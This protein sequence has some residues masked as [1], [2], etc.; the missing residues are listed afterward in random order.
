[1]STI[2]MMAMTQGKPIASAMEPPMDGPEA[3]EDKSHLGQSL[4]HRAGQGASAKG[5]QLLAAS[6]D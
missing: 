1:M 6:S 2:P 5:Q 4:R 3:A